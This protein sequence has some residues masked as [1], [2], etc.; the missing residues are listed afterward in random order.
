MI[1]NEVKNALS[2]VSSSVDLGHV[3]I[4][5]PIPTKSTKSSALI[6]DTGRKIKHTVSCYDAP[7]EEA[8]P[9]LPIGMN[10][11]PAPE[12]DFNGRQVAID[13][14]KKVR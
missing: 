2:K 11:T 13:N 4:I 12:S 7:L 6:P 1:R 9:L 3:S 8:E 5:K 14:L 10:G